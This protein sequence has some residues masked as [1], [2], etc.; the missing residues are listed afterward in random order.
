MVGKAVPDLNTVTHGSLTPI[1][2]KVII[3]TAPSSGQ[4]VV[5][6]IDVVVAV[7]VGGMTCNFLVG[8]K[9]QDWGKNLITLFKL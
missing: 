8:L 5:Q 6:R 7:I 9:K 2:P 1:G 4:K 3:R